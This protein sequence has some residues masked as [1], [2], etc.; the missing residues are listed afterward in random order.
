ME[1]NQNTVSA[2]VMKLISA[3]HAAY[4]GELKAGQ[5]VFKAFVALLKV[6]PLN[7]AAG[8]IAVC[9]AIRTEYGTAEAAAQQ[10]IT[11][12]NNARKVE[13]GGTKSKQVVAG[14]GRQVLL[15]VIDK[16]HTLGELKAALAE[17]KPEGLKENATGARAGNSN[18]GKSDVGKAAAKPVNVTDMPLQGTA[19]DA[20]RAAGKVLAFVETF[21]QP[22]TD[23]DLIAQVEN[24]VK[25]LAAR[26]SK[27]DVKVVKGKRKAA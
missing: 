12:I 3:E 18:A 27:A 19:Q 7:D 11:L 22:G 4:L 5:S 9:A 23:A 14:R 13:C 21:L 20:M 17:A 25:A 1:K 15:E 8:V 16:A 6:I 2:Q 10:R 24:L 26:F